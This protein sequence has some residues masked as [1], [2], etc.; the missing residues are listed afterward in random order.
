MCGRAEAEPF[1]FDRYKDK[2]AEDQVLGQPHCFFG[3]C[4][5]AEISKTQHRERTLTHK[6]VDAKIKEDLRNQA[7][8]GN[9]Y[10]VFEAWEHKKYLQEVWNSSVNFSKSEYLLVH[11]PSAQEGKRKEHTR[12]KKE[13]ADSAEA[14]RAERFARSRYWDLTRRYSSSIAV[15]PQPARGLAE[16]RSRV[17]AAARKILGSE[18]LVQ[19]FIA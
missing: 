16:K 2:S 4:V 13:R 17:T 1:C 18:P 10:P 11:G 7:E 14:A 8:M 15:P 19:A 6:E 12:K 9:K 5:P 3:C